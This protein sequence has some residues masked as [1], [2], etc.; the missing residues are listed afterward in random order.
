VKAK[1]WGTWPVVPKQE[2]TA[3]IAPKQTI[4]P[5]LQG[6]RCCLSTTDSLLL[7]VIFWV[8]TEV[9]SETKMLESP[10]LGLLGPT[11]TFSR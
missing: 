6:E 10:M 11:R 7:H 3:G 5:S 9:T 1:G 8:T 4:Y 2:E